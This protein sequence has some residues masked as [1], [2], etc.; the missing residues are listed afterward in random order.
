MSLC[1]PHIEDKLCY[2]K[3]DLIYICKQYNRYKKDTK[4]R[5]KYKSMS[6]KNIASAL[7]KKLKSQCKDNHSC[8]LE[9]KF[10]PETFKQSTKHKFKPKMPKSWYKNITEWLS[11]IEI[12]N[13][14]NQYTRKYEDFYYCGAVPSDCPKNIQCSLT[15]LNLDTKKIIGIVF[16]LDEHHQSGSHWVSCIIDLYKNVIYYYDS[17]ANL[18]NKNIGGFIQSIYHKLKSTNKH[19]KFFYN[20]KVHQRSN[21]ECGMFSIM[22]NINYLKHRNFEK[23]INLN[24]ND[25]QMINLRKILF[26]S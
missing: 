21:T 4:D 1:A 2:S 20:K 14:L 22:F 9:Q 8:W 16:N 15:N 5:I 25:K 3:D 13:V 26:I 17:N 10:I 23:V 7:K 6:K 19:P 12:D 18:P 24:P 11:T